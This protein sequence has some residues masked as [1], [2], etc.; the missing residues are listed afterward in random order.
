MARVDG[1][2]VLALAQGQSD[3]GDDRHQQHHGGDLEAID[4]LGVDLQAQF[5]GAADVQGGRFRRLLEVDETAPQH[6][7][8]LEH[9]QGA[10]AGRQGQVAPEA[11]A[12]AVDINVEHH[13]DEEEQHHD[14]AH[15]DQHQHD[16]E[17]FGLQQQPDAGR[18][19]EGQHQEQRGVDR[20]LG[21][22]DAQCGQHHDGRKHVEQNSCKCHDL[23]RTLMF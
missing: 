21:G 4:I 16:G 13:D 23:P 12:H 2:G 6:G 20:I 10:D 19:E 1:F 17:E 22:D 8:H 3:G 14:G 9:D 5:L 15:I 7:G 18:V 11:F